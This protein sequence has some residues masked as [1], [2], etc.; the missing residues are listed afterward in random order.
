MLV[1]EENKELNESLVLEDKKNFQLE[2]NHLLEV[3]RLSK[4]LIQLETEKLNLLNQIDVYKEANDQINQK[5]NDLSFE[6]QKRVE[7]QDH[8]NKIGDLKRYLIF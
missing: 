7:L 4:R 6:L 5:F 1:L 3:S 2:K 8:L